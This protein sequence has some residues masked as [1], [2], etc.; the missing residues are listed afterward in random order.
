M[1]AGLGDRWLAG[2]PLEGVRFALHDAVEILEGRCRGARGTV[3][4][5]LATRPEP[6]YLVT[7]GSGAGDVRIRQTDLRAAT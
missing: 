2:E 6:L 4:L 1:A 7:V 5:L 3:V